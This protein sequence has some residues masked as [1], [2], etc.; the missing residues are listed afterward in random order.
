MVFLSRAVEAAKIRV[1]SAADRTPSEWSALAAMSRDVGSGMRKRR[2]MTLKIHTLAA[3]AC[4]GL[5]LGTGCDGG[6]SGAA[7]RPAKPPVAVATVEAALHPMERTV[8]VL[9]TLQA[10]DR[11]TVSIK[12]TGRLRSFNVDI[13]SAVKAGDTLVQIEPRDYELRL[14]QAQALLAQARARLGLT[15]EGGDDTVEIEKVSIVREAKALLSEAEK[16][17]ARAVRLQK[18]KISSE[19]E[20]ERA[21][22][23]YQVNL[24]RYEDA[25]QDA[26]ERQALLAQRRAELDIARQQLTDTSVR[27][28]FDGVVQQRLANMGEF[29]SSGSPVLVLV[30]VDPLKLR[31]EVPERLASLVRPQQPVRLSIDGDT[32]SYAGV[33]QRVSPALDEKTRML[34]VEAEIPN[35]GTLRPGAFAKAAIVVESAKPALAIP[36]D[37]IVTFA[38]T[39]RALSIATNT[40][41]EKRITTGRRENGL[42][43]ILRGLKPGDRVIRNPGGLQSGDPVSTAA[44]STSDK[45]STNA[46]PLNA[47]AR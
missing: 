11:A 24:N 18:E 13:G 23:D 47:K 45:P 25:L 27:A 15:V 4:L 33:L 39:E 20:L 3:T 19:A 7:K 9:G 32:N 5:L 16:N 35:P 17:V 22:A 14:Q 29:V 6:G 44:P 40:A 38:G 43:E 26:R 31:A 28:P 30:R 42:V 36:E 41:V 21:Q 46:I 2:T 12:T 34:T 37:A 8:S 10:M 1:Q